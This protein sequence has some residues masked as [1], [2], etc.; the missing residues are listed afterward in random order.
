[1]GNS[2]SFLLL[3]YV[4]DAIGKNNEIDINQ[5]VNIYLTSTIHIA[6]VCT[7]RC[8]HQPFPLQMNC[9]IASMN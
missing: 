9:E 1:M 2:S 5:Y 8:F 7:S 6:D 4:E 3:S